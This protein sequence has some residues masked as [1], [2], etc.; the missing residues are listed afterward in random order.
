MLKSK[1]LFWLIMMIGTIL[2]LSSNNWI[3][4]WMGLE[5]N[6]MAFIPLMNYNNKLS[7]ES[8]MI[9][10][11]TQSASSMLLMFSIIMLNMTM[12]EMFNNLTLISLLIKLGA[13][14]FHMW[15]PEILTKMNWIT[16]VVIM[17][18]QKMAPMMMI[19]NLNT[20]NVIMYSSIILSVIVGTLGGLN[21]MSLRKIMAYSSINH[22]G[23]MMMMVKTKNN[24][25]IYLMIYSMMIMIM[26]WMFH[27]YNLIHINQINNLNVTMM[28][29]MNYMV[30]MLSLGGLPPFLGFLP[31]WLVIQTMMNNN[32]IMMLLIMVTCSLLSLFYYM[33]T[34]TLMMM[35]FSTMNKW[36]MIK[37]N[38][39]M[40]F[41]MMMVNFS[42]PFIL[43]MNLF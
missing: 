8:M 1:S 30:S 33:R 10:L 21:Q 24:W 18:W 17:T 6:L 43:I 35:T 42:L 28:E 41:T 34:M 16:G 22:L 40:L 29:K 27:Q 4:M 19:N 23:W 36:I 26:C 37:S 3:S 7:S 31:K 20:N 13:A 5:I 38:P 9:Y 14:P 2:V 39:N 12:N 15:L 32:L 11:L 25:L